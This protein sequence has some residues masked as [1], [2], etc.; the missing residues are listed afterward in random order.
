MVEN[1]GVSEPVQN[2]ES[3]FSEGNTG[4]KEANKDARMWAMF[5]HLAALA[6]IIVPVVGCVIG[7]L[8]VWQIKKEEFPFVDEQG[9][10]AVNFQ[11]TVLIYA[12]VSTL[13]CLTCIGFFLLPVVGI[14][15]L[16]FMIIAA[17]KANDGVHY[18]YPLT[19]R[20]VK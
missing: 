4:G 2:P 19:I 10:E 9:K 12:I 13:L 6:G 5:S 16:V 14:F 3:G 1:E 8:V 18:R 20:F 17:V 15:E 7:P 11:I